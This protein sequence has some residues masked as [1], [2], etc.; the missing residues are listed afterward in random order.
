M[1]QK[2]NAPLLLALGIPTLAI[3]ASFM[4][5][6]LAI[7]KPD[8]ELP[9]QY[10]WEGMRLDRDFEAANRA[11]DLN[12]AATLSRNDAM[13]S[14]QLDLQIKGSSP[15]ALTLVLTHATHPSLD[16]RLTLRRSSTHSTHYVTQCAA[17]PNAH[18]RVEL[19]EPS[20]NWSV[21]QYVT[22]P[23]ASWELNASAPK[24]SR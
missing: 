20:N 24:E 18:W 19:T 10:H 3:V 12:V 1:R 14:C 15:D 8:G 2:F 21:R 7:A 5:L 17:I 23:I 4:T 11:A 16:Q 22:G 13:S 6:A 9:E